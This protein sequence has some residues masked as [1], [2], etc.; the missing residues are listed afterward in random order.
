M[1]RENILEALTSAISYLEDSVRTLVEKDEEKLMEFVWKASADLE[2]ALFLFSLIHQ[3]ENESSSWKLDPHSKQ[4]EIGP[5]LMVAQDLLKEAKHSF[6]VD[7][8]REA[9]KKTWMARGYLLRVHDFFEK[10]RRKGEKSAS[11]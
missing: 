2:Y 10:K 5:N 6:E 7:E 3:D 8:L 4:V 1:R 9:Y 11:S